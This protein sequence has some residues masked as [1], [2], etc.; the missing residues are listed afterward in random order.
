M[1]KDIRLNLKKKLIFMWK[2][3]QQNK[4]YSLKLPI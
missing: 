1:Q 3:K 2:K 4:T